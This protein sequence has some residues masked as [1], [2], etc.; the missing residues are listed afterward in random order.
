MDFHKFYFP[1]EPL[2]DMTSQTTIIDPSVR[3]IGG[4]A[5][6]VAY[7]RLIQKPGGITVSINET[8]VFEK[9][10]NKWVMVHLHRSEK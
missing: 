6:V 9:Q 1:K 10:Y 7:T 4:V 8:R 2:S 5:G 3:I